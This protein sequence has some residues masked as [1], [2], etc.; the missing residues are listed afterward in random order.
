MPIVTIRTNKF[1]NRDTKVRITEEIKCVIDN[2]PYEKG[3][4]VITDITDGAGML[5]GNVSADSPC[6]TV[7]VNIVESVFR[8][9]DREILEAALF[10][11]TRIICSY[12][13]IV[14]ERVYAIF[15]TVPLW[16][17]AGVDVEK[18]IVHVNS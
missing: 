18:T 4:Y 8:V 1:L 17:A 3:E 16:A 10:A 14:P 12:C 7:E 13:K 5:L 11:I 6:A 9:V 15:R 2:I